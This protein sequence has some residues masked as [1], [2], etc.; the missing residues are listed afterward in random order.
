M[1]HNW[2]DKIARQLLGQGIM[3]TG[4]CLVLGAADTGKTTLTAALCKQLAQSRP[5]GIVD[6]DIGQSHI[7]PPATV[8]WTIVDNPRAEF[9][10]LSASGISFVGHVTPVGHLLQLTAAVVQCIQQVSEATELI[11]IDTPGFIRG[12]AAAALWWTVQRILKPRLIL[13]VQHNDELSDILDGLRSLG[14]RLELIKPPPQIPAKSLQDRQRYRQNQFSKYFRD[15]CLY[16]ISLSDTAVQRG[17]NLSRED[18][19]D[20]LVGL[21]DTRGIDVAIGVIT[22]WQDDRDLAAVKAP[23][24]DVQQIR[25]LVVGDI[26]INITDG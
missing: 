4:V 15:S 2:A 24:L 10:Q 22:D 11:I 26:S 6:A 1:S 23:E 16:N 8:G 9:S 5:V 14:P 20:R 7:G 18:L 21:R 17:R 19:L 25:C 13:A 3:Q 12:P